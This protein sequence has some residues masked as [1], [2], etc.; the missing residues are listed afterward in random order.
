MSAAERKPPAGGLPPADLGTAFGTAGER[1]GRLG[2][3]L[4][5]AGGSPA[6]AERPTET[7]PERAPVE[8]EREPAPPADVPA[9]EPAGADVDLVDEDAPS[10][11]TRQLIVYMPSQLR[12]RLRR[13]A[14]GSTQLNVMLDAVE[15]TESAGILGELVARHQAPDTSGLFARRPARGAESNV[16]VNARAWHQHVDVLDRLATRYGTNR[17]ELI[18]VALEHVLPGGPRRRQ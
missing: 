9:A 1:R 13:A 15:Q 17:S 3:I 12:A 5:P 16:Q 7:S 18:R 6:V 4:P 11:G 10:Q 2:A 14:V 8:P